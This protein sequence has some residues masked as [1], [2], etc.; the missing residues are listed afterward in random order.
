MTQNTLSEEINRIL[1]EFETKYSPQIM[2]G[3]V[4]PEC[5]IDFADLY[6][7]V[8]LALKSIAEKT[9]EAVRVEEIQDSVKDD[10]LATEANW[11]NQAVTEQ[12]KLA[13]RWLGKEQV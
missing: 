2:N 9:V 10:I 1:K 4:C 13:S 5:R 11:F 6:G 8:Y 3:S 7:D 12:S